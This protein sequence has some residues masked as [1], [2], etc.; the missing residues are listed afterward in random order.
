MPAEFPHT[1][2]EQYLALLPSRLLTVD[3]TEDK[4]GVLVRYGAYVHGNRRW[5]TMIENE[6]P[7]REAIE[8]IIDE[9]TVV[10]RRMY[11]RIL[12]LAAL[13]R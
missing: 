3:E 4:I 8:R 7:R 2:H 13:L 1:R 6:L 12:R 5:A 9:A 10:R 11:R